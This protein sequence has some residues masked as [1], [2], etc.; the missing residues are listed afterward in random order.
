MLVPA[1]LHVLLARKARAA[2][3]I[4][5]G[6]SH[7]TSVIGWD[8]L[9]K[10]A[11]ATLYPPTGRGVYFD[12]H[13]LFNARTGEVMPCPDW[14]WADV[15]GG[16]LAWAADGK[17]YAG[18]LGARRRTDASELYDFNPMKFERLQAPY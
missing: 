5:R 2:I 8:R 6:P 7:H 13:E 1:R 17:L 3:V 10:A 14:E 11:H 16:R 15:D 4:R 12:T 9:C 18:H